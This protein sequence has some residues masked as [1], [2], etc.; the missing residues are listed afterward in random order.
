MAATAI[1][2]YALVV[3]N[4]ARALRHKAGL[5]QEELSERCGIFRTYLSRIEAG[6]AN[7]TL[8]VL[9]A[10]ANTLGVDICDLFR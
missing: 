4:R 10:L 5:S 6:K 2:N 1:H 7:P 8:A 3:G 9:V